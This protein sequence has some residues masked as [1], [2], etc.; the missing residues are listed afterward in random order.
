VEANFL[1]SRQVSDWT[2]GQKD[3]EG[4][5]LRSRQFHSID[6]CFQ[7]PSCADGGADWGIVE[8]RSQMA[9]EKGKRAKSKADNR[10]QF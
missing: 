8:A 7:I 9:E 3:A 2:A 1:Q 5:L 4:R 10:I 6:R